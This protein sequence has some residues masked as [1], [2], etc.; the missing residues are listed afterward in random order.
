MKNSKFLLFIL[1]LMIIPVFSACGQDKAKD[2][3]ETKT[4]IVEFTDKM[5]KDNNIEVVEVVE[6]PVTASIST[7]G[8]I[9]RNE[10]KFY[11]ISSMMQG[12]ISDIKVNLGDNVKANQIV[13]YL[14][15][16]EISSINAKLTGSLHENRIAIQ[17]A[18]TSYNLAKEEYEREKRLYQAGISPQKDLIKAKADYVLAQ[19]DLN[20]ARERDI[21]IKQE[22]NAVMSSFGVSP[23]F[24]SEKL[25]N[26]IPLIAVKDGVITKKNATLGSVV[27][28][29]QVLFEVT[30]L[31]NLWL[32]M[33]IYPTDIANIYQ[34]QKIEF[35]PDSAKE[36]IFEG[37]IDYLQPVSDSNNQTYTARAF[38][39]NK[40][41]KLIIGM[42]GKVK[43]ISD[44]KTNKLFVP[45]SAIQK[46]G[47]E[48]FVFLDLGDGKYQKQNI[49]VGETNDDGTFVNSGLKIGDKVVTNGSFILKS[50]LLK[51][52][53]EEE[54]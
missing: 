37:K 45:N 20:T 41:R 48:V 7:T 35:V 17:K 30:D 29:E 26:S 16:P 21:H 47:K 34:G 43:I 53:F 24:N 13:A 19:A 3:N 31:D 40:D 33:A 23:N 8:I 50:E 28:P 54:D 9:R 32:D 5:I 39:D 46:Y 4:D 18:Q 25:A 6:K 51:S 22:A 44:T 12:K 42:V 11:T 38:L 1:I 10:D 2:E 36:Q 52:E 14:Q 49:E 27:N 15:N